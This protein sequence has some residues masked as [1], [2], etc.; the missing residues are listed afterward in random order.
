[1]TREEAIWYLTPISESA[2]LERYK[3]ALS[4]AVTALMHR[5]FG[6]CDG[7]ACRECSNKV[8]KR[9]VKGVI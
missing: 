5:L 7:H 9:F 1:M 8:Y 6:V 3:E 2:S 4:M